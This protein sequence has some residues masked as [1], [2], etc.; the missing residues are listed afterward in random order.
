MDELAFRLNSPKIDGLTLRP[1]CDLVKPKGGTGFKGV[2]ARYRAKLKR[3]VYEVRICDEHI[4]W[5]DN[6]ESAARAYDAEARK[7]FG[8]GC[9][10]NFPEE[11]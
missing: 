10:L 11:V 3:D 9:Y 6:A 5:H 4:S 2:R 1:T 8:P 7:R